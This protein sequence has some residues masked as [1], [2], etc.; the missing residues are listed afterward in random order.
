MKV[1]RTKKAEKHIRETYDALL[2]KWRIKFKEKMI[3]TR[4]GNTHVTECGNEYGKPLVMFHGV[5]DDSALMWFYNARALGE[6]FHLFAVDTIGGPGKS[7]IGERYNKKFDD[8]I[9]IDDILDGLAL[10]K[11]S[12]VG[13]SHGGYLVQLYALCRSERVDKAISL[14][15][16]VPTE[17]EGSPM[18]TMMKIFLPEALFPTK[19]NVKK[20]IIKLSGKHSEVFTENQMIMEHY[21]WLLKGFNNMA[22]GYHKVRAFSEEEINK[23]R[24][25]VY[26]L[27]GRDDPFEKLGG[28]EAL[29]S[30]NMHVKFYGGVG[31]GINHEIAEEINQE[32]IEWVSGTNQKET[33]NDAIQAG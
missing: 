30:E 5:G 17:T 3:E 33:V 4:Y 23:I 2:Q 22:M 21:A 31:H 15:A 26:Y 1:Y 6:H 29:K 24:S 32:I 11:A 13:V 27:V 25:K 10:K 20:L 28:A 14:A 7:M 12:F 16:S 19:K 18:K 8:V 9:W